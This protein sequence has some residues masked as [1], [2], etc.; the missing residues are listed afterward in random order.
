MLCFSL[1]ASPRCRLPSC[2]ISGHFRG[3]QYILECLQTGPR[4]HTISTSAVRTRT[5]VGECMLKSRCVDWAISCSTTSKPL[6]VSTTRL[7]DWTFAGDAVRIKYTSTGVRS[8][9]WSEHRV[10]PNRAFDIFD[11]VFPCSWKGQIH[12]RTS[13]RGILGLGYG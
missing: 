8:S 9:P 13:E 5:V 3:H 4:T 12:R 2:H 10:W 7:V 11:T 1:R 6:T